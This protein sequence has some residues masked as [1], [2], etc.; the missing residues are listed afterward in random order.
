MMGIRNIDKQISRVEILHKFSYVQI[1][2][3]NI[4]DWAEERLHCWVFRTLF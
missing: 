3:G 2:S 1:E 4:L